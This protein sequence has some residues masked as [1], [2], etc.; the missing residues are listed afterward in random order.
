M[1]HRRRNKSASFIDIYPHFRRAK[2]AS[3]SNDENIIDTESTNFPTTAG[4]F[5]TS[6]GGIIGNAFVT[7]INASG[8]ALVYSTYLGG[9]GGDSGFGIAV[10]GSG[11]AYVT[12]DTESTNF[13]TANALQPTFGGGQIDAFVTKINPSGSALGYSTYLGGSGADDGFGIAVDGLGNAY[14]T[15]TTESTNFPTANALQPTSGGSYD[16]FVTKINASGSALVYSTYLGGSG[17]DSGFGIAVDGSGNAYV[18]GDT[19][20]T[21]FPTANALQ[22]TF[23][24]GLGDAFVTEIDASGSALVYSTYLGGS[25]G[26]LAAGIAVDASSNAYVTGF[27]ISTNFPT[28]A[29]AFQTNIGGFNGNAFVTKI[30]PRYSVCLLYDPTKA[31]HSGATIPIKLQLCDGSGNDLSSSSI[32]VHAISVIQIS[33]SASGAVEDSGNSNPDNDFRFDATLGSTGGYIFNLKTTGLSTGT[34]KVNFTVT[35]DSFVYAAPFQVK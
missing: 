27:T 2:T 17:G 15:G 6:I 29:G 9:S 35:G 30:G 33:T 20:S 1:L 26:D 3:I 34:Y 13:P 22:P 21:N 7:K 23:D 25:T 18:T 14:V 11:N 10:D 4:A 31:V 32:T 12:G 8:S 5:Q 16:A 24:G 19:E 28:T